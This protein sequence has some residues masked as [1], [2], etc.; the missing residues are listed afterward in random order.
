VGFNVVLISNRNEDDLHYFD[1]LYI[2]FFF[3]PRSTTSKVEQ[4]NFC[5]FKEINFKIRIY[6]YELFSLNWH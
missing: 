5:V 2:S 3:L 6:M 1:M 4:G